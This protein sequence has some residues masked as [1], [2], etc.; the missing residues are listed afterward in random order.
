[1]TLLLGTRLKYDC[2]IRSKYAKEHNMPLGLARQHFYV[3]LRG[4]ST[5]KRILYNM[6]GSMV[7]Q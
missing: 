5:K 4:N 7:A 2:N 6:P 1:M 3:H